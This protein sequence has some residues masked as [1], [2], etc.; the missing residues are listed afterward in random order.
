MSSESDSIPDWKINPDKYLTDDSGNFLLKKDGTPRKKSGRAKGS[1]G[2]GYAYRIETKNKM[3]AQRVV[4]TK[5]KRIE[6]VEAR[7]KGQRKSLIK[8]KR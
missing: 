4:R 8:S 2:K 5:Q 6:A 7:L 1:K 3:E